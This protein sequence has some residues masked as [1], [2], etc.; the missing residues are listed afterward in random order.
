[1]YSCT[2][3]YRTYITLADSMYCTYITLADS[4]VFK[5]RHL[6]QTKGKKRK[7]KTTSSDIQE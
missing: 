5:A 4:F 3:M 1:M 7:V 2:N 6:D